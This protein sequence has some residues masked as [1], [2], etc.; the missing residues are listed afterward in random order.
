MTSGFGGDNNV[1]A[2]QHDFVELRV[3][4]IGGDSNDG[5]KVNPTIAGLGVSD[6][7]H[8]K[9][10]ARRSRDGHSCVSHL[11]VGVADYRSRS[12]YPKG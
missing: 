11:S 4:G 2:R 5:F 12:G 10:W 8:K 3:D 9:S 7:F 1:A 6:V